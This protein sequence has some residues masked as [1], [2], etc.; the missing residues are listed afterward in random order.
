M[1][2]VKLNGRKLKV[3]PLAIDVAARMVVVMTYEKHSRSISV[4]ATD[5]I[6]SG[7]FD[8]AVQMVGEIRRRGMLLNQINAPPVHANPQP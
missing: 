4:P 1:C 7:G 5:L 2:T 8:E 6:F 3:L